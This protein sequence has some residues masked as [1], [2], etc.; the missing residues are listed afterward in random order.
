MFKK[1]IS[2]S[3]AKLEEFCAN[4]FKTVIFFAVLLTLFYTVQNSL[5]QNVMSSE[6][7]E[8]VSRGAQS[9]LGHTQ[10]PPLSGWLAYA[11][12]FAGNHKDWVLY[13]ATQLC[14]GIS[15]VYVYKTAKLFCSEFAAGTAALLCYFIY[16]YNPAKMDFC[17]YALEMMIVPIASYNFFQALRDDKIKNWI[18]LGI[19]CAGGLLNQYSFILVMIAF[20]VIFFRDKKNLQQLKN[21]RLYA[22]IGITVLLIVPHLKWLTVNDFI[23]VRQ[24]FVSTPGKHLRYKPL[25]ELAVAIYPYIMMLAIL[26]AALLP[27]FRQRERCSIDRNNGINAL[28]IAAVPAAALI[29]IAIFVQVPAMSFCSMSALAA[30][31]AVC[32]FPRNIDKKF[33]ARMVVLL[34]LF[35]IIVMVVSTVYLLKKSQPH[36]HSN[37]EVYT[38]SATNFYNQNSIIKIPVVVGTAPEAALL[39]KYLPDHPPACIAGDKLALDRYREKIKKEGALLIFTPGA[40]GSMMPPEMDEFFK[41]MNYKVTPPVKLSRIVYFYKARWGKRQKQLFYLGYLPPENNTQSITI[42][43]VKDK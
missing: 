22:A 11:I 36:V 3:T 1:Y 7:L 15:V 24:M 30:V 25:F 28:L 13:L 19:F 26:L 20:A 21:Y 2:S 18:A 34:E 39:E 4:P 43:P 37:P 14:L 10:Y 38:K 41:Q 9:S 8:A 35:S 16:Y 29:M 27:D 17:A 6:A 42:V 23:T 31:A 32:L 5:L 40:N 33:F 12:S